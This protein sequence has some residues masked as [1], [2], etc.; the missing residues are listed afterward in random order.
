MMV[1]VTKLSGSV[2]HS[3]KEKEEGEE[4]VGINENSGEPES[5]SAAKLLLLP[6]KI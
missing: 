1:E 4:V 5:H 2:D 6:Q 3:R